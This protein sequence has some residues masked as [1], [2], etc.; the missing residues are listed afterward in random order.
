MTIDQHYPIFVI[1]LPDMAERRRPLI[2]ALEARGLEYALFDA[3][4]GRNGLPER[5]AGLVDAD[6]RQKTHGRRMGP[7]E[8]CCALSHLLVY[9][10]M[11]EKGIARAIVLEDDAVI[12]DRFADFA[13]GRFGEAGDLCLM[14]H[15]R[16]RALR[17]GRRPGYL[18]HD[19]LRAGPNPKGAAA[20]AIT[21]AGARYIVDRALPVRRSPDWPVDVTRMRATLVHPRIVG[22][23]ET[24]LTQSLLEGERRSN[25]SFYRKSLRRFVKLF[26]PATWRRYALQLASVRLPDQNPADP[27]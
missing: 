19:I 24:S 2:E 4:D 23:P 10:M 18:G 25:K 27:I 1:S 13:R 9:R 7:R 5:A 11:V 16:S 20:Y 12:G 21:L 26:R 6:P 15:R 22:H 3:V 17:F 8:V 14:D